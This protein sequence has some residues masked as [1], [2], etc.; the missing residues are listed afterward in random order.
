[1]SEIISA[2]KTYTYLDQ[3]PV[4]EIDI[5]TGLENTLVIL[6]HKLKEGVEVQRQFDPG[7]PRIQAYGSE[8]NQVWTNL[9]DNAIDAMG[10]TG[11]IILRTFLEGTSVVVEVEDNGPGI[12]E[13][14]QSRLF[15]PFFTTKPVGKGTGL[16]L[17]ISYNIVHKHGGDIK[18]FSRPGATRFQVRL[19]VNVNHSPQG[20]APKAA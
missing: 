9:I 4:Q 20:S 16:G 10:G 18:A 2:L 12:P 8:L 5:H 3:A 11:L 19:P 15:S 7:L 6:R 13:A 1:M 17:N 14:V